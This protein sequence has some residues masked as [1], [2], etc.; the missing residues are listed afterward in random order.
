MS[1]SKTQNDRMHCCRHLASVWLPF[2]RGLWKTQTVTLSVSRPV[3]LVLVQDKT[4]PPQPPH[5]QPIIP[6][7]PTDVTAQADRMPRVCLGHRHG[8]PCHSDA[9]VAYAVRSSMA[10]SQQPCE[11]RPGCA[12][13][14]WLVLSS[15]WHHGLILHQLLSERGRRTVITVMRFVSVNPKGKVENMTGRA[16]Q[17]SWK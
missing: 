1:N 14:L 12:E 6:R 2:P 4:Q 10:G 15:S 16:T 5:K 13:G 7:R 8:C 9:I 3:T 11:C 17:P